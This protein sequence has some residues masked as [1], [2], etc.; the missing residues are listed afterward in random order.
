MT[1]EI[2]DDLNQSEKKILQRQTYKKWPLEVLTQD[3]A[4]DEFLPYS[5]SP[6]L[7]SIL[8]DG[9]LR[10]R[11]TVNWRPQDCYKVTE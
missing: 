11:A 5:R 2:I 10:S 8:N 7:C 4:S 6:R 1:A 3:S 9:N